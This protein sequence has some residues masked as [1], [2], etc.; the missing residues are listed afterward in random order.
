MSADEKISQLFNGNKS[1][2]RTTYDGLLRKINKFGS[3]VTVSPTNSYISILRQGRKFAIVQATSDRLDI[4]IKL[5]GIPSK[6]R[7]E[8]SGAWNAMVTHRVQI[9]NPRQIDA[10]VISWLHQAYDKA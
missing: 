10:E 6:G 4:G 8:E 3:D 5:K 7:L 1:G 9:D 2:W